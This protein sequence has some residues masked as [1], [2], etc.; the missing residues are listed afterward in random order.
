MTRYFIKIGE[1]YP[2]TAYIF[3]NNQGEVGHCTWE[4]S[5]SH[6][7]WSQEDLNWRLSDG[8]LKEVSKEDLVK[9]LNVNN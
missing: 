5:I 3:I 6:T 4:G 2:T 9:Y 1:K 8:G 7:A